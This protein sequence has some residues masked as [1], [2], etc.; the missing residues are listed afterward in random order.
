MSVLNV[1]IKHNIATYDLQLPVEATIREL[2]DKVADLTGVPVSGQKLIFCGKQL[3]KDPS[4]PLAEVTLK[5]TFGLVL[6]HQSHFY[7]T[8]KKE[9]I[10]P[11]YL[12]Q[13]GIVPGAGNKVMVLGKKFDPMSD[14]NYKQ[15]I[16]TEN[17]AI[18]LEQ[19]VAEIASQ[20]S[21]INNGH[22]EEKHHKEVFTDL[23]K[24]GK[25]LNEEMLRMLESLDAVTLLDDQPGNI[26]CHFLYQVGFYDTSLTYIN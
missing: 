16:T 10:K 3:S 14:E 13:A 22:L 9:D 17:K 24:R 2:S 6:P 19:R 7:E 11:I 12:F 18:S 4:S 8:L 23:Q 20:L 1:R 25:N 5:D 15:L 26:S 21:D